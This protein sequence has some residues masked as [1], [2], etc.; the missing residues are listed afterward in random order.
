MIW[1]LIA[2]AISRDQ[3][4]SIWKDSEL[5]SN[6][7]NKVLFFSTEDD[8]ET[9]LMRRLR[10]AGADMDNIMTIGLDDPK[11][12]D[13]KFGSQFL[14]DIITEYKPALC[15]FDPIQS[16]LPGNVKMSE[17]NAMRQ[18]LEP[19]NQYGAIYG[20]TFMLIVHT[21][22]QGHAY[23]RTRIADSSD[24]WD[25]ARSVYI[26]GSTETDVELHY[27]SHEKCNYCQL[28]NTVLY[29]IADETIE[30]VGT[31]NKR[32]KDFIS[33]RTKNK[34]DLTKEEAEEAVVNYLKDRG[35]CPV[36]ELDEAIISVG[37]SKYALRKA[38]EELKDEG[39][40]RY[41]KL[42]E[43]QANGVKWNILLDD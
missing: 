21:N 35:E 16:F 12:T 3:A 32:D 40:I 29:R 43:G 10:K 20:T 28:N 38:K 6:G 24:L 34:K 33:D 41:R 14:K 7:N 25:F 4:P 1:V 18:A 27:L 2:A 11:L 15:I 37:I 13:V 8:T 30:A 23:G 39:K 9:V 42:S 22:K 31:T 19:L 26:A 5:H 17:R 36:N